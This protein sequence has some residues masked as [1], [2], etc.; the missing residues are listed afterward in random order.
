MPYSNQKSKSMT[1]KTSNKKN[2]ATS[3]SVS[4]KQYPGHVGRGFGYGLYTVGKGFYNGLGEFVNGAKTGGSTLS[5]GVRNGAQ[6]VKS[7]RVVRGPLR[8][9]GG[10]GM[11]VTNV[12][13]GTLTGLKTT[14][15]GFVSGSRHLIRGVTA[16]PHAPMKTGSPTKKTTSPQKKTTSPKKAMTTKKSSSPRKS[17]K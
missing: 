8:M 13:S 14:A 15:N 1:K 6:N 5:Q 17:K 10:L 2:T 12:A 11:G 3:S 7:L 4:L 9:V 16:A